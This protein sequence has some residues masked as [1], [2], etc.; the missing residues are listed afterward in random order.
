MKIPRSKFLYMGVRFVIF[1]GNPARLKKRECIDR[2]GFT[3][4][5]PDPI[6]IV[7]GQGIPKAH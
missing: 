1:M 3:P 7:F 2:R 4:S 6:K 5:L